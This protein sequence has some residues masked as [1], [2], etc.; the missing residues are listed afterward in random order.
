MNEKAIQSSVS[1]LQTIFTIVLTLSLGEAFKQFV[2]EGKRIDWYRFPA[3]VAFLLLLIPYSHGMNRYLH[4]TYASMARPQP[5]AYY[6]MIDVGAFTVEAGIFF[7]MS[8][9]L[10]MDQW[11]RFYQAVVCLLVVDLV[12]EIIVRI[13]RPLVVHPLCGPTSVGLVASPLGASPFSVPGCLIVGVSDS[14]PPLVWFILD[15]VFPIILGVILLLFRDKRKEG[16]WLALG[17]RPLESK[18]K[19]GALIAL[20]AMAVR[21][22]FD[23]K[24]GWKLYFPD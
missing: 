22:F 20:G 18:L 1:S 13:S 4:N 17:D 14:T 9:T 19:W 2:G 15:M 23:Y 12:W 11:R 3:L 5:Y 6:L 10:S 8:R 21:T 16:S 24:Q 7:V